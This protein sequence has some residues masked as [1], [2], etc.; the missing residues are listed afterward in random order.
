MLQGFLAQYLKVVPT[1]IAKLDANESKPVKVLIV[2]PRYLTQGSFDLNFFITGYAEETFFAEERII[3]LEIHEIS[4]AAALANIKKARKLVR[5]LKEKGYYTA[6][7]EAEISDTLLEVTSKHNYEATIELYKRMK[8]NYEAAKIAKQ[9]LEAMQLLLQRGKENGLTMLESTKLLYFAESALKRG[10][11]KEALSILKDAESVLAMELNN[12]NLWFFIAKHWHLFALLIIGLILFGLG[13]YFTI[14]RILWKR[15][16]N[17]L[18]REQKLILTMIKA[19]QRR[20]FQLKEISMAEYM[21]AIEQYE[22]RLAKVGAEIVSI[23][24]KLRHPFGIK[25]LKALEREEQRIREMIKEVQELYFKEKKFDARIYKARVEALIEELAK[26][27]ELI[28][29]E[30]LKRALRLKSRFGFFWKH[31]YEK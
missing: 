27:E 23:E 22:E 20:C 14:R 18:H 11:F 30:L 10:Q 17:S 7:L 9:K 29:L 26:I 6:D 2:A 28:A 8:E 12:F 15:K 16:L 3:K 21:A 31:F 25:G 19:T 1:S 24:S 5:E 13:L 4:K